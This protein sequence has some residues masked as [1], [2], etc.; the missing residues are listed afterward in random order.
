MPILIKTAAISLFISLFVFDAV[1]AQMFSV[2]NNGRVLTPPSS[3]IM[4]GVEPLDFSFA[5]SL[6]ELDNDGLPNL[7]FS[8]TVYRLRFEVPGFQLFG[9]YGQDLGED[10]VLNY[11]NAGINL[12]GGINLYNRETFGFQVP[13]EISTEYTQVTTDLGTDRSEEFRQ[14][15]ILVGAGIGLRFRPAERVRVTARG[16]PMIGYTVSSHSGRGG[17]RYRIENRNRLYFDNIFGSTGLAFGIDFL[18]S[19]YNSDENEFNYDS[20]GSSFMV[21]VTF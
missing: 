20:F 14:S 6:D 12:D 10:E 3:S 19:E 18:V 9:G 1:K 7:S 17:I 15:S 16:V 21:G 2:G 5:G 8:N 4:A 13:F 11:L